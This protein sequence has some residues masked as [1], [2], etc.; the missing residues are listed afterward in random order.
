MAVQIADGVM[1]L[2]EQCGEQTEKGLNGIHENAVNPAVLR[3][4]KEVRS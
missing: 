1:T 2:I 3:E 4:I